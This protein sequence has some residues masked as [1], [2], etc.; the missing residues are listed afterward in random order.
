MRNRIIVG[1]LIVLAA[2]VVAPLQSQSQSE[3]FRKPGVMGDSLSQ[4]FYGVTVEKKTQNWAYPVLVAKQAGGSVSYNQLKGPYVNLEDV[5]K[6]RCG[7]ICIIKAI[8][9][10]NE[11]TV[12][13]PTHAGITGAE[14]T[15]V[16]QTSGKCQNIFA[17]KWDRYLSWDK[18]RKK[19]AWWYVT[20]WVPVWKWRQVADCQKP[21]KF[22]QFGLRSAGTQM[23]I[24]ENV[25]PSFIFAA[26]GAN[27]VL[28]TALHTSLDCLDESRF[29]RDF[30]QVMSNLRRIS[31]IKGG[32]LFTVPNVTAIAFLR[33]HRDPQGRANYSGLKA[34]FRGSVKNPD[35]VLDDSEVARIGRFLTMLNNELKNQARANNY[36]VADARVI[37]DDIKE[38]GRPI[39]G[40][41]KS[42]RA[43]WPLP[44]KPGVF[45]LDG[46]HPNRYGHAVLG[47]EL[48][49]VINAK[50]GVRIPQ[51]N[52]NYAYRYD[53][54]NQNPVDLLGFLH[55]NIIGQM[56]SWLINIFA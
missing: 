41:G 39:P 2:M 50:Y 31:S 23:Q 10:G 38:N 28:C 3:L 35:Q 11:G 51:V 18:R 56:I 8:I 30:S 6:L 9:G 34:F 40:T 47:N 44:G 7:P 27:H 29:K 55:H 17:K 19:V 53:S 22:H 13:V 20:Y 36:A 42:A 48:I 15:S 37:F 54:L 21:D 46:V 16:L 32:V 43:D 1:T 33:P 14:Y 4:G 52:E 45:G 25:R 12:A 26:V 24:M 49:K 5:L